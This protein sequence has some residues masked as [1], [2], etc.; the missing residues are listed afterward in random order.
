MKEIKIENKK[1]L[2]NILQE[3]MDKASNRNSLLYDFKGYETY[4]DCISLLIKV[5]K[6]AE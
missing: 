6:E 4:Q 2:I 1:Q 3:I 5:L